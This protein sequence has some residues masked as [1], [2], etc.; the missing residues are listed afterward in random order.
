[1]PNIHEFE[2]NSGDNLIPLSSLDF[3]SGQNG[4]GNGNGYHP[5][6]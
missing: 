1:M 2:E 5:S 6:A 3:N 4:N